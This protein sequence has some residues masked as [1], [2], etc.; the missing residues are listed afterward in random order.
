M[1]RYESILLD[2]M[3]E[4]NAERLAM[5][6]NE[7]EWTALMSERVNDI[8]LLLDCICE[9]RNPQTTPVED[10]CGAMVKGEK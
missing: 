10:G 6:T 4:L 2:K 3:V 1:N 9:W 7:K 8:L 5:R